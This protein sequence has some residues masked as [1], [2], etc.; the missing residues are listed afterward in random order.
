M[1]IDKIDLL[2][3]DKMSWERIYENNLTLARYL[4]WEKRIKRLYNIFVKNY[5]ERLG[6][7]FASGFFKTLGYF[8]V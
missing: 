6:N 7:N 3:N 5:T 4:S 8:R 1:I 2:F